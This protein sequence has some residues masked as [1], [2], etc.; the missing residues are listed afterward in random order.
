M[1]VLTSDSTPCV[2]SACYCRHRLQEFGR[3]LEA[4]SGVFLQQHLK[5]SN[6]RRGD[7]FEFFERQW[8]VLM[9]VHHFTRSASEW[10]LADQ[11]LPECHAQRVEIRAD[12]DRES[13][14]LLRAGELW[15]SGKAP[16]C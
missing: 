4:A 10:R 12:V 13:R 9:V 11:H 1:Q 14:E 6:D 3:V 7:A 15:R 2:D 5:Q 8:R 16:R